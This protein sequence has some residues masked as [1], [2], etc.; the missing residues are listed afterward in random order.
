MSWSYLDKPGYL[1]L[2]ATIPYT[3]YNQLLDNLNSYIVTQTKL[4]LYDLRQ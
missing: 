1:S 4:P 2:A 3:D